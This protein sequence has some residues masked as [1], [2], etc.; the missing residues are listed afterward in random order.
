MQIVS[1][2]IPWSHKLNKI[3]NRN[4]LKI[5]YSCLPSIGKKILADSNKKFRGREIELRPSCVKHRR[6]ADCPVF[7]GKCN[8]EDNI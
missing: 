5:S 1:E 2:Y 7:G 4:S 8:L 3:L 6:G